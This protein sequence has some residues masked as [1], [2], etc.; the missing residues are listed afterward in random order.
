M[1]TTN[2]IQALIA[3]AIENNKAGVI[4]AMNSTGSSISSTIS[5]A[6]LAEDVWNVFSEEGVSSL[7]KVLS[8]V[9]IDHTKVTEQEAKAFSTK[10]KNVDPNAKFGDFVK[11][12]GDYFGDLLGGS[13]VIGGTV[14][15][16][17]S[18]SAISP[19][20]VGLIVVVG[21]ILIVLF[22]KF[23]GLVVA[24]V[25]IILAVILYGIFAKKIT[26][27]LTGGGSVSHGGIGQ[28]VLGW[29]SGFGI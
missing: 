28:V 5:D 24:I 18:E 20:L 29:L 26:T 25:V 19:A 4:Q 2:D 9:P 17:F 7:Q 1:I 3:F 15:Q 6:K 8:K 13:T 11:G 14:Q 10:F 22:R 27:T 16:M 21:L 23:I 12:I